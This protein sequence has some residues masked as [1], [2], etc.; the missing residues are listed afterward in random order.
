MK[1][2]Y[3]YFQQFIIFL[4]FTIALTFF[5]SFSWGYFSPL[6]APVFNMELTNPYY[7]IYSPPY[8]GITPYHNPFFFYSMYAVQTCV[9]IRSARPPEGWT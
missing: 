6:S 3:S 7:S 9:H 5:S 1:K 4:S 8:F 2:L